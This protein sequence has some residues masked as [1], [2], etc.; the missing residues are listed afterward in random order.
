MSNTNFRPVI[1]TRD[2]G[3]LFCAVAFRAIGMDGVGQPGPAVLTHIA[4]SIISKTREQAYHL[5]TGICV[6]CE[7]SEWPSVR[8]VLLAIHL[9]SEPMLVVLDALRSDPVRLDEWRAQIA[10]NIAAAEVIEDKHKVWS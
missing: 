10:K 1:I 4:N 7:A 8:R 5:V 2:D 3:D 6:T 9:A